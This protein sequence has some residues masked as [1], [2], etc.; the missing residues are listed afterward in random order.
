MEMRNILE[1]QKQRL[2]MK[3]RSLHDVPQNNN[4]NNGNN[5]GDDDRKEVQP[6]KYDSNLNAAHE[7]QPLTLKGDGVARGVVEQGAL[8]VVAGKETGQ[9]IDGAV[10]QDGEVDATERREDK[11]SASYRQVVTRG[12][13]YL[14]G[15]VLPT[16][17][18]VPAVASACLAPSAADIS[19]STNIVDTAVFEVFPGQPKTAPGHP[20][21]MAKAATT[22][23]VQHQPPL[24]P[25]GE[26]WPGENRP[27]VQVE[28]PPPENVSIN[29]GILSAITG[30]PVGVVAASLVA[31]ASPPTA[32]LPPTAGAP[33][34][35]I[36]PAMVVASPVTIALPTAVAPHAPTI[37]PMAVVSSVATAPPTAVARQDV[38]ALPPTAEGPPATSMV[39]PLTTAVP[40]VKAS[41][42]T[43]ATPMVVVVAMNTGKNESMLLACG[44]KQ[45]EN[46]TATSQG[47]QAGCICVPTPSLMLL[48]DG[49][50]E[51][52][53]DRTSVS[54]QRQTERAEEREE[55]IIDSTLVVEQGVGHGEI[56]VADVAGMSFEEMRPRGW[57][58]SQEAENVA[59]SCPNGTPAEAHWHGFRQSS[60]HESDKNPVVTPAEGDGG[61]VIPGVDTFQRPSGEL[62][63]A[64]A[65]AL[66]PAGAHLDQALIPPGTYLGGKESTAVAGVYYDASAG[67]LAF[68]TASTSTAVESNCTVGSP[69]T[70]PAADEI[71]VA[72][73]G[74]AVDSPHTISTTAVVTTGESNGTT[75]VRQS[76]L[77]LKEKSSNDLLGRSPLE[78][79]RDVIMGAGGVTGDVR[80]AVDQANNNIVNIE[81]VSAV[82][83]KD[84]A[85]GVVVTSGIADDAVV[86]VAVKNGSSSTSSSNVSSNGSSD[87]QAVRGAISV[88]EEAAGT[89][90][91]GNG[92]G[93]GRGGE[94][95]RA[96][97][98]ADDQRRNM[99]AQA[100]LSFR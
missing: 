8:E 71:R 80:S 89:V 23:G 51:N 93:G 34:I 52:G 95:L 90:T 60:S 67:G 3:I 46:N 72:S 98:V 11:V 92:V 83:K 40:P 63:G 2:E 26:C 88:C 62:T 85:G 45:E 22:A 19:S 64:A 29:R 69:H 91:A 35:L 55:H 17:C 99:A 48:P 4:D 39:S 27:T 6:L 38:L 96:V 58:A 49:R 94:Q 24:P 75:G 36:T 5:D 97:P 59:N 77:R 100:M 33:Q 65:P 56:V 73:N 16:E 57:T 13:E 53:V 7:Q 31:V 86:S 25:N 87:S 68:S 28:I 50:I 78:E 41:L 61:N 18:C 47:I 66:P 74:T 44:E 15:P 81:R 37:P 43:E 32:V 10:E 30:P 76:S 9:K 79:Q 12:A 21:I 14:A 70:T 42:P 82:L 54:L 20:Q 84:P 1:D